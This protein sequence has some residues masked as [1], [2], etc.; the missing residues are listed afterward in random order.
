M[1][2]NRL[3]SEMFL[4]TKKKKTKPIKYKHFNW[5]SAIIGRTFINQLEFAMNVI[6]YLP[7]RKEILKFIMNHSKS[8]KV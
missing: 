6:F 3:L 4:T 1:F 7:M 5:N 8:L 2:Q